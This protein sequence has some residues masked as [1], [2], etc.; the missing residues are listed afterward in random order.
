MASKSGVT[1]RSGKTL[2]D[3]GIDSQSESSSRSTKKREDTIVRTLKRQGGLIYDD[4][5]RAEKRLRGWL[6]R[7]GRGNTDDWRTPF[8]RRQSR[9]KIVGAWTQEMTRAI[10]GANMSD[11][12]KQLVFD[13][14]RSNVDK[15]LPISV[16]DPWGA[17]AEDKLRAVLSDKGMLPQLNEDI[18]QRAVSH[19]QEFLRP[20]SIRPKT[21]ME[22]IDAERINQFAINDD[23]MDTHTNSGL[24]TVKT[25]WRPSKA[26]QDSVGL[27]DSQRAFEVILTRSEQMMRQ[28]AAGQPYDLWAV[29]SNRL[30]APYSD[31]AKHQRLIIAIEKAEPVI[32]KTFTPQLM[33]ALKKVVLPSGCRPFISWYDLPFIDLEMQQVLRRARLGKRVILSGDYSAYD[34][35]LPP[36]LIRKAAEI[37]EYWVGYPTGFVEMLVESMISHVSVVT[38][39]RIHWG[40]PSSMKSGS[41]GTNLLDSLCNLIV[42]YYGHFAGMFSVESTYVMGDD[43]LIDGLG[44]TP[45]VVEPLAALFGLDANAKKQWYKS[46]SLLYLQ[47]LHL[48]DY[49]GGIAST[50]RTLEQTLSYER[51]K[52]RGRNEWNAVSDIVRARSQLENC[53]NSP[54]FEKLVAYV[55]SGDKYSLGAGKTA[56]ELLE[57]SG[58]GGYETVSKQY[59]QS[60]SHSRDRGMSVE[61]QFYSSVVGGVLAGESLPPAGSPSRFSREYGLR[62]EQAVALL[63]W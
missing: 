28:L 33:D 32:W 25:P 53:M 43:F 30:N 63:G 29:V 20:R 54:A 16:V 36:W 35:S 22:A 27:A 48:L 55:A 39:M 4:E 46:D 15:T 45:D 24:P 37:I 17:E 1:A 42:I 52:Y 38:P 59:G 14:E 12:F 8:F 23:G 10:L 49:Y 19:I 41:G 3:P 21:I 51:L 62:G 50:V 18:L 5:G 56:A 13:I 34:A 2:K 47:K 61:E 44:V 31:P 58:R 26:T 11:H 57:S 9:E 60:S 6:G 7:L 40:S